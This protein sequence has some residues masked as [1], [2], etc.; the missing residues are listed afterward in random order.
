M[1]VPAELRYTKSHE[2]VKMDDGTATV[3][4][5]AFA[6]EQLGDVVFLELPAVGESV[7]A[8]TPFGVVESVKA[9]VDLNC[10]VSGEIIESNDDLT[11]NLELLGKDPYGSAWMIKI[12]TAGDANLKN[13]MPAEEYEKFLEEEKH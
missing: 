11:E 7:K 3:G 2:W 10:P 12:K 9:A 5:T 8:E 6:A 4:I 1:M 13:L